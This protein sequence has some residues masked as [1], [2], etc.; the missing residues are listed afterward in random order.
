MQL[1]RRQVLTKKNSSGNIELEP[2]PDFL[3]L[4]G[5]V[6]S[7]TTLSDEEIVKRAVLAEYKKTK[8]RLSNTPILVRCA[9]HACRH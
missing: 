7:T 2:V 8:Q 1:D 5:S 9:R 4:A 6:V 3:D